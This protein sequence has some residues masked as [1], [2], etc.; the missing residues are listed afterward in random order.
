LIQKNINYVIY[1][2][3]FDLGP[4]LKP[5]LKHQL[6]YLIGGTITRESNLVVLE[7]QIAKH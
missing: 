4:V 1:K 6:P 5:K 7:A 2:V 3:D